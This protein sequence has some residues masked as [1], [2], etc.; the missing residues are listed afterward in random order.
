M[1]GLVAALGFAAALLQFIRLGIPTELLPYA[2]SLRAGVAPA[3]ILI[4]GA[5]LLFLIGKMFGILAQKFFEEG[6]LSPIGIAVM[7][8][9]ILAGTWYIAI[10]LAL[11]FSMLYWFVY[12]PVAFLI[13]KLGF[14]W[15]AAI[16]FAVLIFGAFVILHRFGHRISFR[17]SGRV[18][19]RQSE[20]PSILDDEETKSGAPDKESEFVVFSFP[21]IGLVIGIL[22]ALLH[23]LAFYV[24]K[25]TISYTGIVYSDLL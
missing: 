6:K 3:A 17:W 9:G 1:L 20:R 12:F 10:L 7:P 5:C 15:A 24:V 21:F 23:F 25:I 13:N 8:F 14:I 11:F 2:R 4:A 18:T 16:V 19:F 22:S